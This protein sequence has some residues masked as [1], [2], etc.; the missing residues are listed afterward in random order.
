MAEASVTALPQALA[1]LKA[2]RWLESAPALLR[3]AGSLEPT[4]LKEELTEP[5]CWKNLMP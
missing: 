1:R 5:C 3:A 4:K 2:T